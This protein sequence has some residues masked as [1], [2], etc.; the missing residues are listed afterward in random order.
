MINNKKIEF[1]GVI[2]DPHLTFKDHITNK[3]K[4]ALHNLS[5]ICRIRYFSHLTSSKY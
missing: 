1:L 3:S 5:L 2:L 4:M